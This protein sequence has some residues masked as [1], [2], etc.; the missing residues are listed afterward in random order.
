[1]RREVKR[2]S[3]LMLILLLIVGA[4]VGNIIGEL[5][6]PYVPVLAESAVLGVSPVT[7]RLLNVVSVTLGATLNLSLLGGLGAVFGFLLWRK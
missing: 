3:L 7:F 2:Q 1:M 5:V 4:F 6:A